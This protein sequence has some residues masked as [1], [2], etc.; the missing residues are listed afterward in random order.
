MFCLMDVS[1]SMTEHMKDLAKRFYMLLHLFL[2]RRYRHVES[3]SSATRTRPRRSTRRRSSTAARPAARW[4]R[5]RSRR[6][7]GSSTERYP[8]DDW[9][10]YAAQASD[11]DNSP[12]DSEHD[13]PRCCSDDILPL[14]QYFAYLEVGSEDERHADRLRRRTRATLWQTYEALARRARNSRCARSATGARSIPVFRELFRARRGGRRA[15]V[16]HDARSS[17][18]TPALRGRRLGFRHAPA[19]PR[20][21]RDDRGRRARPRHLS[22]PDRDDHRRAD[23][24]RLRLDRHAA[25]LQALVVRQ[26]FRAARGAVPQGPAGPGLRDRHQLQ[27]LHHATSWRR[28]RR[29]CR[30]WSSRTPRSATTTSSRT[31]TCSSSGPT[32]TASSTISNSPRA[33]SRAARSATAMPPVERLL[34]AAHALMSPRR[35]PLSAQAAARPALRGAARAGAAS[36]TRSRSTTISGAPCRAPSGRRR[37]DAA[38]EERRRALLELP[39]ENMLYFLEKTAPRLKPWQR[40]ILRIV[41]N[42]AQYFYPQRQTKVMNEGCATY[43]H[44]AIMTALHEQRPDHRRRLPGIPAVAHQRRLP[45]GIR[46]PALRRHQSLRARLRHD[47]AT[48]SASAPSR[49][50]RT[51]TG[52]PR[53]PAA[54]I[55]WRCC[56]RCLGELPRRELHLAVPQPA[57]DPRM[58]ACSTSS[59]IRTSRSSLVEAI[60]DERGYRRIRRALARQYDVALARSRHPGGRRRSRRGPAADPSPPRAQ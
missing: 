30:R 17:S 27:S 52:S 44:Y 34:D 36:R 21:D 4:C 23:A 55:P 46:R 41:R 5:P 24:R 45:A 13:A 22:Q 16:R 39:Q 9:N 51:A 59:T 25:D 3:S 14:C 15:R 58:A 54:A 12:T 47:A 6:C 26:A 60:H 37:Q 18:R 20:R 43:C 40:E 10:I 29:R 35:P 33:T 50:R 38:D 28:T 1:G 49:P 42:I 31:T 57:P 32:P 7:S 8:P 11:G 19:H 48:S 56:K 53:S 2:K